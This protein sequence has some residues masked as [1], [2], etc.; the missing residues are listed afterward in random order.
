MIITDHFVMLNFP[1]TGSSFVRTVLKKVH[2]YDTL[3][4][5]VRRTLSLPDS[6][7]MK[8]LRLPNIGQ[9]VA[10]DNRRDQHGTY[11][12]IPQQDQDKTIVTVIRN[13]FDRYTST[14]LFGF[15]KEKF[16]AI[17][18][19]SE[20][21]R[22]FP[23]F[24]DLTFAEYYELIHRYARENKLNGATPDAD[25]GNHT[26][27]FVQF[28]FPNPE[29]VLNRMDDDY[30][31]R[32]DYL[33]EMPDIVFLHQERLNQELYDFLRGCGYPTEQIDFILDAER[34]NVTPRNQKQRGLKTF[35]TP[36]LIDKILERDR[37]LFD[38]F[39]EYRPGSTLCQL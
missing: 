8:E 12:Q 37:L 6:S 5:R 14:Y 34:V 36:R 22:R 18:P 4:N 20:L 31:A 7:G 9:A 28:Y 11:R 10:L 16:P 26:V 33:E 27:H 15:W 30:V 24:P 38:L 25:L 3:S 23:T 19:D 32:Q 21:F 2:G 35:Y 39:P 17:V 13:P 29:K 1:K